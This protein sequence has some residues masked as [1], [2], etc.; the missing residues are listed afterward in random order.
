MTYGNTK[1]V[2]TRLS[3][4]S[5]NF[6]VSNSRR[7]EKY[8][9]RL[10]TNRTAQVWHWRHA[11]NSTVRC[12]NWQISATAVL[13][14]IS[15]RIWVMS[16]GS[17]Y[18]IWR[19]TRAAVL[20]LWYVD[21]QTY[22]QMDTSQLAIP[23]TMRSRTVHMAV[24]YALSIDMHVSPQKLLKRFTRNFVYSKSSV[25]YILVSIKRPTRR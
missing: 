24:V 4:S 12:Q 1:C 9:G 11:D 23:D 19:S 5:N 22:I 18:K 2:G 8:L 7:S 15:K 6:C 13:L 3:L 20:G 17:Q 25:T 14:T 21:R 10:P 16:N